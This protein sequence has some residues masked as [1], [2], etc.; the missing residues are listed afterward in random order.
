MSIYLELASPFDPTTATQ[1]PYGNLKEDFSG[2][3][4]PRSQ[5]QFSFWKL[6]EDFFSG[7]CPYLEVSS[8]DKFVWARKS[9]SSTSEKSGMDSL[10]SIHV[11]N[12]FSSD[13]YWDDQKAIEI[14]IAVIVGYYMIRQTMLINNI[15]N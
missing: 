14:H 2:K 13:F 15:T 6:V 12:I 3:I 10:S 8:H 4:H 1:L 11:W 5:E 9:F 7:D